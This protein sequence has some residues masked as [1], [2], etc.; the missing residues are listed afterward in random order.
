MDELV[1]IENRGFRKSDGGLL[2]RT[3]HEM[4]IIN[5]QTKPR[6]IHNVRVTG[7][8]MDAMLA[9]VQQARRARSQPEIEAEEIEEP[10]PVREVTP[11]PRVMGQTALDVWG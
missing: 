9:R 10:Q 4:T 3:R 2:A 7:G 5:G 8:D 6:L 11:T 1:Y